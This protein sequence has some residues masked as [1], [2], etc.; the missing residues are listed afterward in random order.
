MIWSWDKCTLS[1]LIEILIHIK[2]WR[3][4]LLKIFYF[5]RESLL[6]LSKTMRTRT[7]SQEHG[8][9]LVLHRVLWSLSGLYKLLGFP[10]SSV[11]HGTPPALVFHHPYNPQWSMGPWGPHLN[12]ELFIGLEWSSTVCEPPAFCHCEQWTTS[13]LLL[14]TVYNQPCYHSLLF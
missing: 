6:R 14:W 1:A 10:K 12:P 5:R 3:Y 2:L 4:N 8:F 7:S 11:I 9:P 13:L